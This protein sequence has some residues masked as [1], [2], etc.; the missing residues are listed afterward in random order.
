MSISFASSYHPIENV[1]RWLKGN[2]HGHSIRSDGAD[3]PEAN[4][5]A[6]EAAGYDYFALSEH[7]VYVDPQDYQPSTKM[8]MLP[9]V[10]I[11]TDRGQTLM[12]L[13]ADGPT[14]AANT[15][16][17]PQVVRYVNERNGLF[18]AD[19]PNWVYKPFTKHAPVE[20]LLA[21][22]EIGAIE[23]Y[24]GTIERFEGDPSSVDVWDWMLTKGRVV[25]GHATDDQHSPV[26]RFL[27][28]NRVQLR[29]GEEATAK[30]IIEAL[31]MGRF[32]ASTGVT[33]DEIGT[34]TNGTE[35]IVESNAEELKW[36]VKG[37]M[38]ADITK[39]GSGRLSIHDIVEKDRI[40][41]P[42]KRFQEAKDV[43]YVRVEAIGPRGTKAWSQPFFIA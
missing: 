22:S 29:E 21:A 6:Y 12:F 18:I 14:P 3:T 2:H 41:H 31:R 24:T 9:A 38:V 33:I 15:L 30:T 37:G 42:W 20:E 35:I 40:A 43:M 10:E 16:T 5:S 17:L 27:G 1:S 36:I 7:D 28:W 11:T 26:D 4:I 8:I 25:Y 23:I 39:G 34:S 32:Y 13:G 19:H